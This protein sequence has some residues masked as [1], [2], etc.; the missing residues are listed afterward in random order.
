MIITNLR[1]LTIT[2]WKL[3]L[4]AFDPLWMHHGGICWASNNLTGNFL[5]L[6]E[7]VIQNPQF[8]FIFIVRAKKKYE[9]V[10]SFI[11]SKGNVP[12][13]ILH[14]VDWTEQ[15][16]NYLTFPRQRVGIGRYGEGAGNDNMLTVQCHEM[17]VNNWNNLLSNCLDARK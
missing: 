17:V 16:W 12:E 8:I 10:V 9:E 4:H 5:K 2:F 14:N 1:N 7:I 13:T 15:E 6:F 11:V 3:Y